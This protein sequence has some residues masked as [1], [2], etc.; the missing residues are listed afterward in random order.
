[1]SGLYDCARELFARGEIA[2]RAKQ[3]STI[4]AK[5]V[6]E[7]YTPD[8]TQDRLLLQRFADGERLNLHDPID[9]VCSADPVVFR[10]IPAGVKL[11]TVVILRDDLVP[12]AYVD[13]VAGLPVV[14]NGAPIQIEWH[15]D[16]IFK[17]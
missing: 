1:M 11:S 6:G 4:L 13:D 8:P 17:L 3:G 2:W 9:G 7:W 10:G 5:L 14:S 16:G 15:P 12:I